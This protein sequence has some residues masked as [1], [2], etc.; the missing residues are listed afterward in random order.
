MKAAIITPVFAHYREELFTKLDKSTEHTFVHYST[1]KPVS[2]IAAFD[3]N[4]VDQFVEVKNIRLGPFLWQ[5]GALKVAF[6]KD[7]DACIFTGDMKYLSTWVTSSLA[8]LNGKKVF[9]W[10][11]GWHRRERGIKRLMRLAF[12]RIAHKLMVYSDPGKAAAIS[13]G[14]PE[15]RVNVIYNSVTG[16]DRL[17]SDVYK[18]E[19]DDLAVGA[20]ARMTPAKNFDMLLEAIALLNNSGYNITVILVGEGAETQQLAELAA[21]LRVQ[22]EFLGAIHDGTKIEAIYRR[23]MITVV[24]SAAGLTTIQSLAHGVPVITD[25][26]DETQGPEASAI[27]EGTT[28]SRYSA[29]DI[30]ALAKEIS[31]WTM[32]LQEDSLTVAESCQLEVSARWNPN[33]QAKRILESLE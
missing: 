33:A 27:I 22:C 15:K 24:P 25:D 23:I 21:R 32:K 12:Y 26:N 10:T 17:S 31:R 1:T 9:F 6:D 8:R 2:G 20:I 4:L 14:Y 16:L 18:R 3:T 30:T 19:K 28:G 29:G 11:I 7:I 13:H 5:R